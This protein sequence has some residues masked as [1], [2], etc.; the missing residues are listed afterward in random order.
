VLYRDSTL[1]ADVAT[2]RLTVHAEGIRTTIYGPRH[3]AFYPFNGRLV[4]FD[5]TQGLLLPLTDAQ[6]TG[7]YLVKHPAHC[8]P[9]QPGTGV[10][11]F[12]LD[13]VFARWEAKGFRP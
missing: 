2:T 1:E 5:T 12:P 10:V 8:P 7:E 9:G 13:K 4:L 3:G 11:V 6:M